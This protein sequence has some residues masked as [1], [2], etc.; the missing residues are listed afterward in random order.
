MC[1]RCDEKYSVGQCC[2]NWELRIIL[3]QDE[4]ARKVDVVTPV[5]CQTMVM[6]EVIELSLNLVV[7]L[8]IPGTIKI[9]GEIGTRRQFE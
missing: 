1:F 7:G 8:T 3:V 5:D 2:K 4:G 9:I 6:T